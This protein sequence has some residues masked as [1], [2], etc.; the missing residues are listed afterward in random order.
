MGVTM[1]RGM[2]RGHVTYGVGVT[3]S[4]DIPRG[5]VQI[6]KKILFYYS[7]V[8]LF[9]VSVFICKP[10]PAATRPANFGRAQPG[11]HT[12][13]GCAMDLKESGTSSQHLP[14]SLSQ[15]QDTGPVI[16]QTQPHLHSITA[17]V[18]RI[19]PT[20]THSLTQRH[21]SN[22]QSWIQCGTS[23]PTEQ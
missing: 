6:R 2:P 10:R 19:L 21:Q 20:S 14:L 16:I 23:S 7:N 18:G 9:F 22:A 17:E 3:M 5:H 12:P 4:R 8:P 1:S 13:Y 11:V 15:Y